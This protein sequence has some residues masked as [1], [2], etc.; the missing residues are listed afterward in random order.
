MDELRYWINYLNSQ[1]KYI[2]NFNWHDCKDELKI[3]L[4]IKESIVSHIINLKCPHLN[5]REYCHLFNF[6]NSRDLI[7]NNIENL[8]DT[9]LNDDDDDLNK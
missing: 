8:I 4:R 7:N 2:K 9:Y 6:I 1:L 3:H 5:N